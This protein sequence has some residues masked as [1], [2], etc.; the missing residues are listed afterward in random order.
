MTITLVQCDLKSLNST[1]QPKFTIVPFFFNSI[2]MQ[3]VI[4]VYAAILND[5]C[6]PFINDL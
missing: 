6:H 3:V 2:D 5:G 1:G 4:T